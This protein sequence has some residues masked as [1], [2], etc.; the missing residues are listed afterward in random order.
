M[1]RFSQFNIK[2]VAKGFEGN[3]IKMAR[4]I[5]RE[6]V[7]HA[8]RIEDSKVAAFREK[9]AGKCLHLQISFNDEMHVVFTSATGL[10]EVIQQVPENKFPFTTTIVEENDRYK[11]T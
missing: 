1:N 5:N 2:P 3:K 9:G 6:I 7:V 11:F 4:I 10:I 8:F